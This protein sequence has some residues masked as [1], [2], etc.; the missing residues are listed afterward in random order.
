MTQIAIV[1]AGVSGLA[2]ARKLAQAGVHAVVFDKGRGIGGR[3][4]TRRSGDLR[5]DH[6]APYVTATGDDFD[7]CLR[8]LIGTG[9]AAPWVDDKGH[10]WTVG[11]PGMSSIAKGMAVGLDVRL[12]TQITA[13]HADQAEWRLQYDDTQY[14]A[15]HVVVTVPQPQVAGLLGGAHPLV[16]QITD[17]NMAPGLTLMAAVSGPAPPV[18]ANG[19]SD[20]LALITRDCSK[21]NRPQNE[22]SSWV[23]QAGIQFSMAH[24]EMDQPDIAALMVP[25]L[26]ERL[27]ITT[28]RVTHAA[29]HRWRYARVSNALGQ[30]FASIPSGTLYLGGDWC[31]G[32]QIEDAWTSGTAIATDMLERGLC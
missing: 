8:E 32:P 5:F 18:C 20:L 11:T 9:H 22:G 31:V 10:A 1:G 26:C 6:G 28:D 12:G 7:T 3:V 15:S 29:A 4:A 23:A 17:I 2:C 30:P 27:D 13:I 14:V 25:M 21:P 24:L 16:A 19:S